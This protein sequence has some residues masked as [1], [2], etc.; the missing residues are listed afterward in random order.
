MIAIKYLS[1]WFFPDLIAVIPFD[2][3]ISNGSVNKLARIS[4]I[5][6]VYKLIRIAKLTRLIRFLKI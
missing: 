2:A 6:K 5:G 3:F 1:T 4:R